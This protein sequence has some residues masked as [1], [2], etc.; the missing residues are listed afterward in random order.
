VRPVFIANHLQYRGQPDY[1]KAGVL[2]PGLFTYLV[3]IA[4]NGML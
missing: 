2:F 1:T 4:S 3:K